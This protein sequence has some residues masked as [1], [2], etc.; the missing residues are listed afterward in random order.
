[1][2]SKNWVSMNGTHNLF[3]VSFSAINQKNRKWAIKNV[4]LWKLTSHS[5]GWSHLESKNFHVR[6]LLLPYYKIW[7]ATNYI[8][9][10]L[11]V[12]ASFLF[13]KYF[14][15]EFFFYVLHGIYIKITVGILK[16]NSK[17]HPLLRPM[18]ISDFTRDQELSIP[19]S[20]ILYSIQ[21]RALRMTVTGIPEVNSHGGE[22]RLVKHFAFQQT[23]SVTASLEF[24]HPQNY[25]NSL[26]FKCLLLF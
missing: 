26:I 8:I 1:M 15:T 22:H 16:E 14:P 20:T 3:D 11:L 17:H 10:Y 5:N 9:K 24:I 23:L 18:F 2:A 12:S 19:I 21:S 7:Q 13:K 25:W 6:L 4:S